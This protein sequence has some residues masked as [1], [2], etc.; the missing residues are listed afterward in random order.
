MYSS[1]G[2]LVLSFGQEEVARLSSVTDSVVSWTLLEQAINGTIAP[3][4]T[5]LSEI[6]ALKAKDR[7]EYMLKKASTDI[8]GYLS[9]RYKTPVITSIGIDNLNE[10]CC[11]FAW[12]YLYPKSEDLKSDNMLRLR[13]KEAKGWL[14]MIMNGEADLN[15]G[16]LL[17]RAGMVVMSDRFI[18]V[19]QVRNMP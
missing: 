2:D 15:G 4:T 18:T 12:W 13:Y 16:E 9:R 14:M 11:A 6:N 5:D 1:I 3:T 7:L 8:D 19:E 17:G 10:S